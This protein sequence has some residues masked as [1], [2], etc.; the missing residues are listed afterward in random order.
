MKKNILDSIR[1]PLTV[2][3]IFAGIAEVAMTV[4]LVKLSENTQ[5]IFIWFVMIFPL[6]LIGAFF[7]ILYKKPA[8]LFS[9]SDY[10]K[11]E[12]YLTS[13]GSQDHYEKLVIKVE[14]LEQ[15]SETLQRYINELAKNIDDSKVSIE[16]ERLE[17]LRFYQELEK[18]NLFIFL[19]KE[20]GMNFDEFV[21]VIKKSKNGYDLPAIVF[22]ITNDKDKKERMERVLNNFPNVLSDFDELQDRFSGS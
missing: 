7:F 11:D 16:K 3:V 20:L 8:V 5:Y 15:I 12:M 1:N 4:T 21:R 2:I 18:N 6:V 10:K 14:Q 22:A 9:P 17:E 13:I 19:T